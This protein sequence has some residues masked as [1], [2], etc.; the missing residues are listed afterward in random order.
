MTEE[1][2]YY[3]QDSRSYCGNDVMWWGKENKGYTSDLSKAETYT[4]QQAMQ[5]HN[6]RKTDK[7]WPK[8]YIDKKT[9]PAVD[10]QYLELSMILK[11][12]SDK[13]EHVQKQV[14]CC[15]CKNIH[16]LNQRKDKLNNKTGM[17][18]STCPCCGAHSFFKEY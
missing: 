17:I 10:H 9:R 14:K 16:A 5:K 4:R 3:L 7:A 15:R 2:L 8:N 6:L 18:H 13:Q 11:D 1:E 12:D